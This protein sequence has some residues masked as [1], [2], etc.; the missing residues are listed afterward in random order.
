MTN[1][2]EEDRKLSHPV[3]TQW[4][5]ELLDFIHAVEHMPY[6]ERN[7]LIEKYTQ[8]LI[9]DFQTLT[10]DEQAKEWREHYLPSPT[11]NNDYIAARGLRLN[12]L[13]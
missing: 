13:P 8:E 4:H 10:P 2:T 3:P 1:P 11:T 9:T 5:S 7:E 12:P 6:N